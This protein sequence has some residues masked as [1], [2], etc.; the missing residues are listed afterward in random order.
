MVNNTINCKYLYFFRKE[1]KISQ[2]NQI[3]KYLFSINGY[4]K[5]LLLNDFQYLSPEL[6]KQLRAKNSS[7]NVIQSKVMYLLQDQ[8][9]WNQLVLDPVYSIMIGQVKKFTLIESSKQ[10]IYQYREVTKRFQLIQQIR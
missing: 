1:W 2:R 8:F 10:M 9:S 3:Q 4:K 6:L 5:A 7:P